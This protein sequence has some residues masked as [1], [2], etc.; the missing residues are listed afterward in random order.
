LAYEPARKLRKRKT[1]HE[2]R[3]RLYLREPRRL[4]FHFFLRQ[5]S[6]RNFIVAF[7]VVTGTK[8]RIG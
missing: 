4:G 1:R 7:L 2:F 3:L 8:R 5:A 6:I